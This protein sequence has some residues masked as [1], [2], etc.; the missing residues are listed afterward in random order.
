MSICVT[1]DGTCI[2]VDGAH[3]IV[4]RSREDAEAELRRRQRPAV[5]FWSPWDQPRTEPWQVRA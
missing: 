3:V 1:E 5:K 4:R 2:I